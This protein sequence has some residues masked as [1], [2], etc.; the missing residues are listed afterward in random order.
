M[1]VTFQDQLAQIEELA[2]ELRRIREG[3]AKEGLK[4]LKTDYRRSIHAAGL[5]QAVAGCYTRIEHVLDF[6][7]CEVDAEPVRGERWQ[8]VLLDRVVT[9]RPSASRPAVISR[10]THAML[11][12]L[13]QFRHVAKSIYPSLLRAADVRRNC[14]YLVKVVPRFEREFRKFV[15]HLARS[16][17]AGRNKR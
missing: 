15:R 4:S 7:A 17:A 8:R 2:A 11:D 5:A 13:R 3:E 14:D 6:V 9:A 12:E 16:A 1:K 10:G